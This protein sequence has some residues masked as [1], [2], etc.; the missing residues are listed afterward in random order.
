MKGRVIHQVLHDREIEIERARLEHDTENAQGFPGGPLHIV[1]KDSDAAMLRGIQPGYQRKECALAGSVETKQY[2]KCR[3]FDSECHI[4]ERAPFA[5]GMADG[6]NRKHRCCHALQPSSFDPFSPFGDCYAP[7]QFTHLNRLDYFQV[8]YF[9]DR[10]VVRKAI[11]GQQVLFVG[12]QRHVPD[13]LTDKKILLYF[14]SCAIDHGYSVGRTE[15]NEAGL[16]VFCNADT[17]GLNGLAAQTGDSEA[18]LFGHLVSD[19]IND[20]NGAADFGGNPEL[21]RVAFEHRETRA[22]IHQYVGNDFALAGV[23]EMRHV[24]CL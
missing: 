9:D 17:Y 11:C 19:R 1:A 8:G 16:A 13:S 3:R 15:S 4:I 10:D 2:G 18:D 6:L 23:Y 5:I 14:V 21:R 7:W 22:R 20:A 24:C 12:R